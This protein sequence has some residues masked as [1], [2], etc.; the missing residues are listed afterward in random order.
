MNRQRSKVDMLRGSVFKG[1][2][3][4]S[5]P[6]ILTNWL[7]M[8]FSAA[9]SLIAGKWAGEGALAAVGT[10]FPLTMLTISLFGGLA[11]GVTVNAAKACGAGDSEAMGKIVH[12][13]IPFAAIVGTIVMVIGMLIARPAL[14]MLSAPADIIDRAVMYL[15]IYFISLPA[16][17][18]YDAAASIMRANGDSRRP[19]IFLTTS[20]AANVV[21]NVVFVVAFHWGV[22]GVAIA[23]VLT[24]YLSAVLGMAMLLRSKDV[25]R[26][27]PSK[28]KIDGPSI[29]KILKVGIPAGL[30]SAMLAASDLPLQAAVNSLGSAATSGNAAVLNIDGFIFTTMDAMGQGCTVYTGQS[31]GAKNYG[32]TK[33]V[34]FTSFGITAALGLIIGWTGFFFRYEIVGAFLPG[35]VEAI[36]YGASRASIVSTSSFIYAFLIILNSSL[37]GYGISTEPAV[38]T[39][40]GLF[41][42]RFV[43]ANTIFKLFP[44]MFHI[45]L[46]YPVA[47][48]LCIIV[49]AII[50]K[51]LTEK[52]KRKQL[53]E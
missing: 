37:R 6:L 46:S 52:A 15:R 38:I 30:Q 36:E 12:T 27:T 39:A 32:R 24:Q 2:V 29:K 28:M 41:V 21:L 17:M 22:A 48:I 9:D 14:K 23:T 10:T 44:T 13:A 19:L 5:I 53:Q 35:A 7:H 40:V 3:R 50:Y 51:P 42:F 18:I 47:W 33:K 26:F 16:H 20:G 8:M 4:F 31:V 45:Y 25:C 34:L 49:T 43:W 1:L 11:I